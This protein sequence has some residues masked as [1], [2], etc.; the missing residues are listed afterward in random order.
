MCRAEHDL[1]H[2]SNMK[3]AIKQHAVSTKHNI[4]HAQIPKHGVNNYHKRLLL[5]SWPS[6][7][8]SAVNNER[9]QNET[10]YVVTMAKLL[11]PL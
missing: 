5:E 4:T 8:N 7:L 9:K 10:Y 3:S 2:V 6:I 1:G 11:P